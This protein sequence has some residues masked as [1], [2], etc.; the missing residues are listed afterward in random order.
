MKPNSMDRKDDASPRGCLEVVLREEDSLWLKGSYI[1]VV[2]PSID[3]AGIQNKIFS[4]NNFGC[5]IRS[6]GGRKVLISSLE[7]EGVKRLLAEE[8]RR[9][10]NFLEKIARE[11]G[12]YIS[13]GSRTKNHSRLLFARILVHTTKLER[14]DERMNIKVDGALFQIRVSKEMLSIEDLLYSE[15]ADSDGCK[16][17]YSII[18]LVVPSS[19]SHVEESIFND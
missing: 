2:H 9:T 10:K 6:I 18:S 11:W 3:L 16:K 1:G 19:P 14:I 7:E 15:E 12:E 4:S 5:E 17:V 8:D 13:I